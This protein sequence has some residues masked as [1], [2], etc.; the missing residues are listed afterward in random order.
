MAKEWDIKRTTFSIGDFLSWQ[1]TGTLE[2]SP[3]FQRRPVWTKPQKSYLVDTIYRGLPVPIIF[4]RERT[5]VET[6]STIREVVDGQQRLRTVISFISPE[7]LNNLTERDEF[8][9]QKK[10]NSDIANFSFAKFSSAM[11]KRLLSYQFSVHVL[12]SDTSDA[13]VLSIFA[14]MNSTGSKL[15][16]QELRNAEFFGVFKNASYETAYSQLERWRK[17]GV[18]SEQDIARMREVEMTSI[19]FIYL[20]DGLFEQTQRNIDKYYK[21][22]D[23][24]F[25]EKEA[26]LKRFHRITQT[27]EDQFGESLATSN[28]S[29]RAQFFQ[30]VVLIN[31]LTQNKIEITSQRVRRILALG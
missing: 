13:D 20:I 24:E 11:K 1:K 7:S 14:R 6:L 10:H 12:P 29:N 9:V 21:K 18:F 28:F 25:P 19:I 26:V 2:L 5:D 8:V 30:L 27:L 17:W 16:D 4:L 15:N 31:Q 22:F 3:S 23:E